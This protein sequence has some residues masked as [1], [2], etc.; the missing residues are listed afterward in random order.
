[1][2]VQNPNLPSKNVGT[3]LIDYRAVRAGEA[4]DKLGM[5]VLTTPRIECAYPSVSG[6]PDMMFH[7]LGGE[8]FIVAPEAFFYFNQILCPLGT[9]ALQAPAPRAKIDAGVARI[10]GTYPLDIAYNVARID[11][12][13]FHYTKYTDRKIIEYYQKNGIKLIDIK[14]GYSKCSICI[15]SG[16]AMITSDEKI[17]AKALDSGIDALL[18]CEGHIEL[19]DMPYGFI[20]GCAGLISK[21]ILAV[22][23]NIKKHPDYECMKE[24]CKKH[25]VAIYPLHDGT[26]EDIGS[27]IPLYY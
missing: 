21:E 13:A 1:M 9:S 10:G 24:F 17:A 23:G 8:H 5:K 18:I 7:H 3:V 12:A 20:G 11:S 14:Q 4:F 25:K 22:N 26:L 15:V 19:K 6:H 27:I 2:F 16:K